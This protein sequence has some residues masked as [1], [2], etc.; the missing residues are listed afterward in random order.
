A[1]P[2]TVSTATADGYARLTVHDAG[3]GMPAEF[4]PHAG[5]RFARA[6]AARATPG[7][8]LG[9]SLVDAIVTAHD[10][11]LWWCSGHVHHHPRPA[12][13]TCTH[14]GTGTTITVLL[15]AAWATPG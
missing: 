14:P 4:L 11:H 7:S 2:V 1:A 3:P 6:D 10:G 12:P 13:V 5:E 9:L 15:P 8:G